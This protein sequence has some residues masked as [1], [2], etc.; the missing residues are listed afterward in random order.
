MDHKRIGVMYIPLALVM[1]P[2]GVGHAIMMRT[3]QAIAFNDAAGYLL[4]SSLRLDFRCTRC[5]HDLLR[6]DAFDSRADECGRA[7]ATRRS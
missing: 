7:A 1:L 5:E 2:R 4:A 6:C 3:P